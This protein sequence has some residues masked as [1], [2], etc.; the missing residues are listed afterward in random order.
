MPFH[1]PDDLRY[2]T[3]DSLDHEDILHAVFTR[4]GGVSPQPWMSLNVGGL[5]GDDPARVVENRKR[6]FNEVGRLPETMFD[7]WQVHGSDVVCTDA[8]RPL[9]IP[10]QKADIILT[11]RPD[12][13]LFMRFADCVPVLLYDPRRRVVGLA[14]A[15]WLG[16]VKRAVSSAVQAMHSR[17]GSNPA[18]II[19]AIGPSIAAHHYEVGPEVIDQVR[20]AF[21]A[22]STGLL[23]SSNGD[24]QRIYF[25]LWAANYLILEQ[26]GL[27]Q[28]E[29]TGEC[30]ACRTEDWFSHRGEHGKTGRFG[31]LIGLKSRSS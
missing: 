22:D 29:M 26:C 19:A 9:D 27:R 21:G 5:V 3:F 12:V 23:L 24:G 13:T 2:F 28:I 8:P 4:N 1:T 15:G 6:C 7:V 11:D 20:A 10:H 18:D 17:Y 16:T 14:H 30:T 25:D 31:V